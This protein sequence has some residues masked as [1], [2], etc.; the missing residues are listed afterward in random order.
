[1]PEFTPIG[2]FKL[3]SAENLPLLVRQL[4][5][6]ADWFVTV[7]QQTKGDTE[8]LEMTTNWRARLQQIKRL[9]T[10]LGMSA[11][12]ERAEGGVM[13]QE[14]VRDFTTSF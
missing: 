5:L 4:S 1:M 14:A 12:L 13:A 7:F 2:E 3:V 11:S 6:L 8:K 9:R 10:Q